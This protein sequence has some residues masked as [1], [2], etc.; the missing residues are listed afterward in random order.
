MVRRDGQQQNRENCKEVTWV[1]GM[2][3]GQGEKHDIR[4]LERIEVAKTIKG[5]RM[6]GGTVDDPE[7]SG[8]ITG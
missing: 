2:T 7:F 1:T 4:T 3:L 6:D 5:N 8:C